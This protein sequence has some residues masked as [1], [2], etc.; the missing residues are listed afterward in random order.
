MNELLN[1]LADR[2]VTCPDAVAVESADEK[3]TASE[4]LAEIYS[5]AESLKAANVRRLGLLAQNR[6][7]WIIADLACQYADICLLPLPHF[8]SNDQLLSSIERAGVD[9]LLTDESTRLAHVID[10]REVSFDHGNARYLTLHKIADTAYPPIPEGT[11]KITFT[12]G[13]TGTPRGVCLDNAQQLR[14]ALALDEAVHITNPRHLCLLSLSTLLEN[15][16]GVYYPLLADGT[17]IV[18]PG[19]E[20]GLSGGSGL[21]ILKMI[22]VVEMY[23]PASL[24][25]L[26]QM[27][28]AL[29]AAME[30]GWIPPA[31]LMFVATGGGKIAADLIHMARAGG[32]PVFE[33]YG[34][35]E[36]A[37][38]ACLNRP[39]CDA[40][41]SAGKP[42]AHVDVSIE[43]AEIIVSGSSFLGY[44]DDAANWYG[45]SVATGD[46]GHLDEQGFLHIS[47]RKKNVLISSFG[48]NISPEWVES[49][50]LSHPLLTQCFIF[51]DARPW[52]VA[53]LAPADQSCSDREIQEWV[54]QINFDLPHYARILN[55]HRLSKTLTAE[56]GLVTENG[57]P[58]RGPIENRYSHIIESL[59]SVHP[60]RL[61]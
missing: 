39:D 17:V 48:R 46:L 45:T 55:W 8:F 31:S 9:A 49:H 58:R 11:R 5:F 35:S 33:G 14:A 2:A 50:L 25:L 7:G 15:I 12:S 60:H 29:V 27:L 3:L 40:P 28:V 51:G 47:G 37:S 53:L 44:L 19:A 4:L 1:R 30:D 20:T 59:Y 42:L 56:D 21:D 54:D 22:R 52:C 34:L 61:H 36:T 57:R 24:I 26:P 41:G 6:P 16:A 13:S 38:V 18:P 10:C 32:L 23:Q 43:N